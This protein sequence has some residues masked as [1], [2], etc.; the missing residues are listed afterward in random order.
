MK[1]KPTHT[2]TSLPYQTEVCT[3]CGLCDPAGADTKKPVRGE[4]KALYN[5]EVLSYYFYFYQQLVAAKSGYQVS[6][7]E[8]M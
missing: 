1:Q 7:D 3:N 8:Y 4:S 2:N 5:S 6:L